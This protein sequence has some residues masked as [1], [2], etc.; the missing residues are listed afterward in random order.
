MLSK[1]LMEGGGWVKMIENTDLENFKVQQ[2]V[3]D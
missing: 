2:T 3:P 1:V